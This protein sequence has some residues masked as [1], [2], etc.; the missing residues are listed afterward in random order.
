MIFILPRKTRNR[1]RN[2]SADISMMPLR[3]LSYNDVR[4][5]L[6]TRHCETNFPST[7]TFCHFSRYYIIGVGQKIFF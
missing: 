2:T 3:F 7:K 4:K 5:N 6:N 1:I